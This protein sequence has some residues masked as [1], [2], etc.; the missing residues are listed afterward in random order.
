M[1]GLSGPSGDP[2]FSEITREKVSDRV[3]QE[4]V[5][6]ISGGHLAPGERLPG[7][8]Q[9]AQMM[10]VSR[11]SVRAALQQLKAQGLVD[12]VQGGGTRVVAAADEV[13]S[14]LS[15]LVRSNPENLN[16]LIEIR[17]NLEVWAAEHAA[18]RGK[19]AAKKEIE[20]AMDTMR[21]NEGA[22]SHKTEDDFSFHMAI[23]KAS[24]S[25]VYLHLMSAMEE[26]LEQMI[27]YHRQSV[28]P[29]PQDDKTLLAQHEAINQ[30]IQKGDAPAAGRAMRRHLNYVSEGYRE[31]ASKGHGPAS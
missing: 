31:Q 7:E 16:D 14:A 29:T 28:A 1:S 8:R 23:A 12:A 25:A 2:R 9:L 20:K 10:N 6:L 4:I 19:A 18:A 21:R 24:G 15:A 11:V 5:K 30:A 3:A 22:T 17:T 13:E 26:V 27:S